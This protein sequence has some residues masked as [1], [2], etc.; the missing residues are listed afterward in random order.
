M[1]TFVLILTILVSSVIP[2]PAQSKNSPLT[3][4]Q[5]STYSFMVDGAAKCTGF[6]VQTNR[7]AVFVTA[8]HCATKVD[9]TTGHCATRV[10]FEIVQIKNHITRQTYRV[11]LIRFVNKWPESDYAV[12]QFV[13]RA[14]LV[15]LFPAKRVPR[16]GSIIYTQEGPEGLIPFLT[17]GIYSGVTGC[18]DI[19]LTQCKIT[20]MHI[21]QIPSSYGASGSPIVDQYG[22]VWGILAGGD[23]DLPGMS[24]VVLIP[25]L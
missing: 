13:E 7:G 17:Q 14:P 3:I 6:A 15:L 8:G 18:A 1:P 21:V 23:D 9:C 2:A 24:L 12:F 4:L 20:G 16:V 11:R 22:R 19:K 5:H 10:L 25:Q